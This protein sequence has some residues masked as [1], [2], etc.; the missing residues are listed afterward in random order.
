MEKSKKP[1]RKYVRKKKVDNLEEPVDEESVE[2]KEHVKPKRKYTR[3]KKVE[4][5]KVEVAQESPKKKE[6]KANAWLSHVKD[7]R[8]KHPEITY[9]EALKEAKKTY[10]K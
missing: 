4:E 10:K 6:R 1:K 8:V 3:K 7:Y 2:K 5:K 9:S